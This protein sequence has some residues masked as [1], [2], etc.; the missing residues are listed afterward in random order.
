ME[1]G[2]PEWPHHNQNGNGG[3]MVNGDCNGRFG[4]DMSKLQWKRKRRAEALS[5]MFGKRRDF[6]GAGQHIAPFYKKTYQR[7]KRTSV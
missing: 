2:W 4:N 7:I 3:V 1:E 6:D 5:K